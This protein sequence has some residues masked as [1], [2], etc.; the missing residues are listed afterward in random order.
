MG[1]FWGTWEEIGEFGTVLGLTPLTE[2]FL[3]QG[4]V[5]FHVGVDL[6]HAPVAQLVVLGWVLAVQGDIDNRGQLTKKAIKSIDLILKS[7]EVNPGNWK[8]RHDDVATE[9]TSGETSVEVSSTRGN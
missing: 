2:H 4:A 6:G 5:C 8:W 7:I 9:E 3:H 1:S